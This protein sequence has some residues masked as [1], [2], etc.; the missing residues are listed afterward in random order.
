[1]FGGI[2]NGPVKRSWEI[3]IKNLPQN[4]FYANFV[5]LEIIIWIDVYT[6]THIHAFVGTNLLKKWDLK[7][8]DIGG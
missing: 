6:D 4:H 2:P 7:E 1:M 8:K 5:S 3:A